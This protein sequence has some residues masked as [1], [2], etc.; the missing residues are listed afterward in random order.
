MMS[1]D[2]NSKINVAIILFFL[3]A[4]CGSGEESNDGFDPSINTASPPVITR[5]N[6]T[7]G[8]AGDTITIFG[9]GFSSGAG[10]NIVMVGGASVSAGT[11]ALV[12][13]P[14]AGEIEQLTFV[15]PTGATTGA[16]N[17]LVTVLENASNTV[18]FT[19]NP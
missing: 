5:V 10:N 14:V 15:I 1:F 13:P 6:P 17:L 12:N 18:T 2:S 8:R 3:I 9:L 19:V 7:S 16:G 4:G 11:Y